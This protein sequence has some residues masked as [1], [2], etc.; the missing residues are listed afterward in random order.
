M[1]GPV[2]YELLCPYRGQMLRERSQENHD[3]L[4]HQVVG[5]L[6]CSLKAE[7][8]RGWGGEGDVVRVVRRK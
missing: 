2:V 8:G 7:R 3:S 1:Q 6:V 5:V 4:S